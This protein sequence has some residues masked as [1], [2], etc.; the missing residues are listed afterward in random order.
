MEIGWRECMQWASRYHS[1]GLLEGEKDEDEKEILIWF[2][3][4]LMP[5]HV[6]QS[7]TYAGISHSEI[8]RSIS[9]CLRKHLRVQ[10]TKHSRFTAMG[11]L[12]IIASTI[13]IASSVITVR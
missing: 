1:G 12:S 6:V 4:G 5:L 7:S 8:K 11:L 3:G 10:S 9:G 2:E 13:A